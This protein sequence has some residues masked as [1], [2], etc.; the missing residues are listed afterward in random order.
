MATKETQN[1]DP[2]QSQLIQSKFTLD[3]KDGKV[4]DLQSE[5]HP[6]DIQRDTI[7]MIRN[8]F[9]DSDL[10]MRRP[11]REFNDVSVFTR[12]MLDQM[13]F[14]TYQPN[15]GEPYPAD[16][17][18][19]W[20]SNAMRPIVR[21]KCVSIAAH[22]T[23]QLI[24]PK[25]FAYNDQSDEQRDAGYVMRDLIEWNADRMDYPWFALQ[26]ILTALWSPASIAYIGYQEIYR[27]V[28]FSKENG[29]WKLESMLDEDMTGIKGEMVGVDELYPEN[30]YESDIQKQ[31][32]LIWRKV[33][34]YDFVKSKYGDHPDFQYVKPGVQ[35]LW[36]D[37]NQ[38]FYEVY[39]MVL[40][41]NM[42]EVINFYHRGKDL[43]LTL[44]NG[45]LVTDPDNPNPRKDK[46]YPFI[47]F[48][49]ELIDHGRFFYYKSLA[50]KMMQ[51]ANIV[52]TLYPMVI[53]GTYLS[54][55]PPMVNSGGDIISSD[56]VV[57]G[58]VTTLKDPNSKLSPIAVS[59]NLASGFN[60]LQAVE[61]S[62]Q[63]TAP[64]MTYSTRRETAYSMALRAQEA[65]TLLGL[66]TNSIASFVKQFGKLM[67][68]DILQFMTI[69]DATRITDDSEIMY[70]T[71][72][73]HNKT[74]YGGKKKN[75]KIRFDIGL[76]TEPVT[77]EDMLKLSYENMKLQ[78]GM[79]SEEE[80]YRVNPDLFRNLKFMIQVS[81]DSLSPMSDD[82][83]K[84][85]K[86][87]VYDRGIN[88]PT[89]DQEQ[90]TRDFLFGAYEKINQD[91]DKYIKKQEAVPQQV[92]QQAPQP[93]GSPLAQAMQAQG[94]PNKQTNLPNAL[95]LTK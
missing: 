69:A 46:L 4:L 53:D 71:F 17:I 93:Q 72:T 24:F 64:Q 2:Q 70:K 28:K 89:V 44:V 12:L 27:E 75:R 26:A 3:A 15:N 82:I 21:N 76:P 63:E 59:Q 91:P 66:F 23:A 35:V 79:N 61:N 39:D 14:N 87:E 62:V 95:S 38:L 80:L 16:E 55:I 37:A 86:L 90:L 18:Q 85:Y 42:C 45:I 34:S 7:A 56:V 43:H 47:K 60:A 54:I 40:R 32:W 78:G 57:P 1:Y 22:A 31:G 88:N 5:Y 84:A 8:C 65:K 49:F 19:G 92:P 48:G 83:E 52:N 10:L 73:L 11:R 6:N 9:V 51:D 25:V 77:D 20:K 74:G 41:R 67:I 81:P 36:N 50:F 29:K 94:N 30:I 58:A 33:Q 68:G 13:A